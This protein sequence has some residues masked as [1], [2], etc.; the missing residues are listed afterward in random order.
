[1]FNLASSLFVPSPGRRGFPAL[2]SATCGIGCLLLLAHTHPARAAEILSVPRETRDLSFAHEVQRAIDKGLHWLATHQEPD[3]HWSTADH[4]AITALALIAFRG[5]PAERH[6]R[7]DPILERGYTFL[8]D[9][10]RPDGSIH[11]ERGLISYNTS[12][13]ILALLAADDPRHEPILRKARAYLVGLQSDFGEPGRL[14]SR[15]D[16]GIGYGPGDPHEHSDMSNTLLALEALHHT[17]H[18][19]QSDTAEAAPELD[20]QAAIHFLERCQN[21]PGHNPLEWVSEHPEDRGGFVYSP[22]ESKA[23]GA[24]NEVTGKVSLRSYGSISYAGLLSYIYARLERD[25]PRVE[26]VFD[27]LRSNYTLDE[28]PGMGAQGLFYYY[29]TMAKALATAEVDTFELTDG[30]AVDWRKELALNLINLQKA[31]GSWINTHGRWWERDPALVTAYG[32]IAL[33]WI[34]RGL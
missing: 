29:H 30:R 14:D 12:L 17:R 31:D 11:R 25:D 24:T 33:E 5:D 9:S 15:F 19:A 22:D 10:V 27:W 6:A 4:P 1:M 23:G 20:W 16:G 13:S 7:V 2:L 28:N 3:G 21:L 34:H 8:L 32:V 18:L 26:A